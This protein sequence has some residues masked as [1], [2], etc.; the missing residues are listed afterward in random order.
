MDCY[1][2]FLLLV[3]VV[4]ACL[5]LYH[6]SPERVRQ[7]GVCKKAPVASDCMFLLGLL[8]ASQRFV[9]IRDV[10][11]VTAAAQ[12]VAMCLIYCNWIQWVR[13]LGRMV[14]ALLRMIVYAGAQVWHSCDVCFAHF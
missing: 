9:G 12:S 4:F 3:N 7:V 11:Y 8:A 13:I 6:V 1:V 10:C 14:V 5:L 2:Y